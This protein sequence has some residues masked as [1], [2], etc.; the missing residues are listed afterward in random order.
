M[1]TPE[2]LAGFDPCSSW[3]LPINVV[4]N[5]KKPGKV[6]LVWDA[7]ATVNGVSLNSQLLTGPDLLTPLPSVINRFRERP[8]GFG[9]DI[10]EMYHQILIRKAD[11]RAQLFLF[12]NTPDQPPSVYVMDV[13]TFGSKCSPS[14][15]QYVKNRNA[16][17]FSK[18]FPEAAVA[19]EKK[20]YVDDYF[21]SVDT[22][23][24]AINRAKEVRFIHSKGGFEIRNWV[25]NSGTFLD[26]LGE[27]K[28]SQAVHLNR[29]KDSGT[30]RVL[31]I[32]WDPKDDNFRF[33]RTID[34]T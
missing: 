3:F 19:I 18:Q 34:M 17:E 33:R 32:V 7:A 28:V 1:A 5:P 21:D 29:D 22:V 8:I 12:R 10:R 11:R 20:H 27:A 14:Q 25:S 30:E 4:V 24:E 9:G 26:E 16:S 2:E 31:G 6:R 15:A 23:E 13:A